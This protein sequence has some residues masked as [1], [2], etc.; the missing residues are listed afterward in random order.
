MVKAGLIKNQTPDMPE[1]EV[2]SPEHPAEKE[3]RRLVDEERYKAVFESAGDI[4][5]LFDKKGKIIDVNGKSV[6][7][8]GYEKEEVIG[9]HVRVLSKILTKKSM[10]RVITNFL[11]RMA[12]FEVPPYEIDLIKKNGELLTFEI[13]AQPLRK[14]GKIIGDLGIL[15][16][17]TARK[18]ADAEILQ[19]SSDIN[20]INIINAAANE[21]KAFEEILH[22]VSKETQKLFG[23][24]VQIVYLL[25]KDKQYLT[26]DNLN[27]PARMAR[28]IEQRIGMKIPVIKIRLKPGGIYTEIL[29]RGKP[30]LTNDPEM[31]LSMA[32]ECFEE[33]TLKM[34]VG[35]AIRILGVN[36]VI[37]VPLKSESEII[38]LLGIG[39]HEPFTESDMKRIET[40]AAQLV[41]II[42]R[43][44]T[45]KQLE[46]SEDNLRTYLEN[47]PDGV[48]L[49]DLKGNFLYANKKA[50]GILGFSKE[51]LVGKNY[52]RLNLLSEQY[53]NKAAELLNYNAIG[54]NTGPDEFEFMRRDKSHVWVEINT[55]PIKQKED[56]VVI[57]FVRNI[58]ARKQVEQLYHNLAESSP[59][60]VY[61]IQNSRFV[62]TNP[63]FQQVTGYTNDEL[64]ST[65]PEILVHP[66]D[67]ETVRQNALQMLKG[68]R[69]QPYEVRLITKKGEIRWG[70]ERMTSITYEGKR[71]SVG[72]FMDITERKLAEDK[73]EQAAQEWRTTFDSITDIIIIQDKDNRITRSNKAAADLLKTT[74]KEL[75]GHL[76]QEALHGTA[77]PPVNCPHLETLRTGKPA[78]A[79]IYNQ[80]LEAYFHEVT[81][82]IFNEKGEVIG[83]IM[84]ARDVTK[85]K[86]MEEQLIVTNRLASIG[87]LSSGIAHELNNP[88]TSVIGFS[89]LLM[90]GD[91]PD[92]M[93]ENLATI[94]EEAQRA[95]V[96]VKNLLTFARKHAPVKQLTQVNTVI[97]GV[98]KLRAYEEKVNNIEVEKHL[99]AS[100]S[101]IMM[102]PFQ[103]QQVFLNIIVNA[104]FAMLEAHH[105]GKLTIATERVDNIVKISFADDGPGITEANLKRIFDPFFTTKEVG[106]GT[107]LGLSICHGIV[108]EHGGRIYVNSEYGYGATFTVE[109]PL[110]AQ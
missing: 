76:C 87:E 23:G 89:Q 74:P 102:D 62:F 106:K 31:M 8:S 17:V 108:T 11:K 1:N 92:N 15:R 60:G 44:Q 5:M 55:A 105:K 59:V 10:A 21:G 90:Q 50:E 83:S 22:L 104:E 73:L 39:R 33:N 66:E 37:S 63:V 24:N 58:S 7:I 91:V 98:L 109:L 80:Q 64:L 84:V 110:D 77:E 2:N 28:G 69:S 19:K 103:M 93:K 16:D 57:G 52:F 26:M 88:L 70:L 41:S 30:V 65:E 35:T 34:L 85:Q 9:K 18:R 45:E 14:D 75:L 61:I 56:N 29:A 32:K 12:G 72:N 43:K 82:P 20:L 97:E 101:E 4:M 51:E 42:K 95:A 25:S 68:E 48:Y 46:E 96:I 3:L 6:E 99:D 107:G 40:I 49:C 27:L 86:R 13:S 67:I 54:R 47:A 36:A 100:L 71:A 94:Y 79:E 53:V 38:G 81:S 78:E